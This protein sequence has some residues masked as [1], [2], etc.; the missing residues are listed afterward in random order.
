MQKYNFWSRAIAATAFSTILGVVFPILA[1]PP[2]NLNDSQVQSL[3][4]L[5]IPVAVPRYIPEGFNLSKLTVQPSTSRRPSYE[6]LYRNSQNHCF[7]VSGFVGGI[8]G[9]EAEYIYPVTT[10]L[11]GETT[12]NIGAVYGEPYDQSPSPELLNSPQSQIWSFSTKNPVIY[13]IGTEERR[14]ECRQNRTLTPLEMEKVLQSL[15]WL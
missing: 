4:T 1:N 3:Q 5:E 8:G 10:P 11:F 12:I 9:P 7:Y 6:I 2:G 15:T 13:G 14:E